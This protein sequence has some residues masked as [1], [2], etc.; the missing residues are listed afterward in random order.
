[1]TNESPTAPK[2]GV[3]CYCFLEQKKGKY[4]FVKRC[5][6]SKWMPNKWDLPGGKMDFG[7]NA[8]KTV[9][10]EV[11]EETGQ[12]ITELK[13]TNTIAMLVN[14]RGKKIH[15][16]RIIFT[17]K[18]KGKAK[19]NIENSEFKTLSLKEAQ[20]LDLVPKMKN[21]IKRFDNKLKQDLN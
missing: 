18:A 2:K 17:G 5:P 20:K 6:S 21:E 4:L 13:L 16:I 10:R 8:E 11:N 14:L 15:V 9:R 19:I 12:K 7:E 1:M 3:S